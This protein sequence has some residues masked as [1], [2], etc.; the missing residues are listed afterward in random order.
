MQTFSLRAWANS[1]YRWS[2]DIS[3]YALLFDLPNCV[4]RMQLRQG[5]FLPVIYEWATGGSG[6]FPNSSAVYSAGTIIFSAPVED[7]RNFSG[8][9][10]FDI[11][12]ETATGAPVVIA[13]GEEIFEKGITRITADN[14]ENSITGIPD[15]VE[16]IGDPALTPWPGEPL[17]D[18]LLFLIH[19]AIADKLAEPPIGGDPN[20][21]FAFM[22]SYGIAAWKMTIGGESSWI[23]NPETLPVG[24]DPAVLHAFYDAYGIASFKALETGEV[25]SIPEPS[26]DPVPGR[27][28]YERDI[29]CITGQSRSIGAGSTAISTT[30]PYN[31]KMLSGGVATY[32]TSPYTAQ[33]L[34]DLVSSGTET[35]VPGMCEMILARLLAE[36]GLAYTDHGRQLIGMAPGVTATEIAQHLKGGDI[37]TKLMAAI[38]R[39]IAISGTDGKPTSCSAFGWMQGESDY[40]A[41]TPRQAYKTVLRALRLDW[42]ADIKAKT[43]QAHDLRLI[44]DQLSSHSFYGKATPSIALALLDAADEDACIDIACPTYQMDYLDGVHFTGASNK[45]C[46]AYIG[47]VHK[48]IVIDGVVWRP[49]RPIR[50]ITQDAVCIIEF[51]VPTPPLV[52]DTTWVS[53]PGNYG[54]QLVDAAGAP[55]TISSVA[56]LGKKTVKIVASATLPAG[57]MVRYAWGPGGTYNAG[58]TTGP[59]GNLRDSAGDTLSFT[60]SGTPYAMHNWC[61]I[62]EI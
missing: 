47:L 50:K 40:Q 58:R 55:L 23:G 43:G 32:A 42:D 28:A 15:T 48:R 2:R 30:Q 7:V 6:S 37:Y 56:L 34:V 54:F 35:P 46:G 18:S 8:K 52:L 26:N 57:Y 22:D 20:I 31:S 49:L 29:A 4:I 1:T 10:Q 19:Q 17:P 16:T 14:T 44:A 39:I 25:V 11:R 51:D 13:S 53:N 60:I 45:W 9:Y 27:W 21:A 12:I 36:D 24:A 33:T 62:S 61:L 41:N 38:D 59:R 5:P 3:A